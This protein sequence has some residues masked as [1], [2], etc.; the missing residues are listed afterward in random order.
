MLKESSIS[1]NVREQSFR[2]KSVAETFMI[3]D[4]RKKLLRLQE[5]EAEV[6]R[7][8]EQYQKRSPTNG[9]TNGNQK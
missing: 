9:V 2:T 6:T 8:D 4:I 3:E 1:S 5:K 7:L